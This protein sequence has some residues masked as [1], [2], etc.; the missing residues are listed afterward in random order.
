M[1]LN[2]WKGE[3]KVW[4]M[5]GLN[6]LYF[7]QVME[8]TA[9]GLG[10]LQRNEP[11]YGAKQPEVTRRMQEAWNWLVREGLLMQNPDQPSSDWFLITSEG[12]KLLTQNARY[13]KWERIGVE[14]VKADLTATG[15]IREVGGGPGVADMAWEWVRM[16][17][18]KPPITRMAAGTW[19]LIDENR[20]DELR[21][22]S[23]PDFDFR[24]L[25]RLCEELNINSREECHFATGMLTRAVLDHVPPVFRVK[26]FS[27][28]A[29]NYVGGSKSFRET[30]LHLDTAAKKI[31]DGLLHT[32]IRKSEMLPNAQ[33]VNFA[34]A[35][36]LLLSE[37]VR[38]TK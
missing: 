14:R 3:G 26:L 24:K 6:R 33:Q 10:T 37:I 25:I 27:E 17:E 21:A 2:S 5:G 16:K 31:A 28:L 23:S 11:E 19:V 34:A 13:E 38:I 7:V 12:E 20:L 29:N 36:D 32:Q 8:G 30:M 15:G 1:H 35:L 4:Q 9:R 22:L 18:N